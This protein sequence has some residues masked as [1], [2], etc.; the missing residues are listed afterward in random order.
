MTGR[1]P[2]KYFFYVTGK[3]R[4]QHAPHSNP[5]EPA[6]KDPTDKKL[7][8]IKTY[9]Q[10]PDH[11]HLENQR[12][13]SQNAQREDKDLFHISLLFEQSWRTELPGLSG[14]LSWDNQKT[15]P[16]LAQSFINRIYD[17]FLRRASPNLFRLSILACLSSGVP[18]PNTRVA[19]A[20][21]SGLIEPPAVVPAFFTG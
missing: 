15:N 18:D 12:R 19:V 5:K 3:F 2:I 4:A 16:Y 20:M 10:F 8:S 11:H 1:Q 14:P 7:V 9:C 21:A 13:E 6:K 17:C